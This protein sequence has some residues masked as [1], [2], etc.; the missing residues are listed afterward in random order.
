MSQRTPAG[1]AAHAR[2]QVN[3][4][5]LQHQGLWEPFVDAEPIRAQLRAIQDTGIPLRIAVERMGLLPSAVHYVLWG[6]CNHPPGKEV[7]KDTADAVM[8]YWPEL[9]HFPDSARID[10]VG[11]LRRVQAL[12]FLGFGRLRIGEQLGMPKA[13]FSRALKSDRVTAKVARGVMR[14]YDAWWNQRPEDHGVLWWVA[15]RTRKAAVANG[16]VGPLAWDDGKIDDPAAVPQ[17]DAV[18]PAP[19][20]GADV[21]ARWLMGESVILSTEAR[22]EAL[23][24]LMEWTPLTKD[25]VAERLGMNT[26]A[27]DQAWERIK[28]RAKSEGV[29]PPWRRVY[30]P[31][32]F[33]NKNRMESAA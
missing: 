18:A 22:R 23:H 11:T 6:D 19:A 20:E 10:P 28:S 31:S 2:W 24:H 8:A 1:R 25:E 16:Y 13:S 17:T 26:A 4:R 9:D 12:E 7:R 14:V 33:T 3:R 29:K 32:K 30:V 27:V 5:R 21:F 15:D